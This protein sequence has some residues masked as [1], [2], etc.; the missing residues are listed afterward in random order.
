MKRG[1]GQNIRGGFPP[2]LHPYWLLSWSPSPGVPLQGT[3][4]AL[5]REPECWVCVYTV[6]SVRTPLLAGLF[7]FCSLC[8]MPF[9]LLARSSFPPRPAA[10]LAVTRNQSES[11]C[12][13]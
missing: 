10:D 9:V 3:R 13:P 4:R 5:R 8:G 1:I 11:L 12:D 6:F 2:A 7:F